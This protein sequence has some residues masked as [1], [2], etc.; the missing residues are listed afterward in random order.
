[1]AWL[2]ER[3]VPSIQAL[4]EIKDV[5][6]EDAIKCREIWQ[7]VSNRREAREQIDG[8]IRTCG[9]EYLGTHKRS[10]Q[11]VYYCN[12]GDTYSTTIMSRNPSE[13][14]RCTST[15]RAGRQQHACSSRTPFRR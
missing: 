14:S 12:A 13:R 2:Y 5:T 1:M 10:G 9:V 3:R 6:K 4:M 7:T 15:G 11:A 8:L